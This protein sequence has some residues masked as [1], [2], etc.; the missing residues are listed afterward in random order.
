MLRLEPAAPGGRFWQVSIDAG[1]DALF[2]SQFR[3]DAIGWDG[4][5]GLTVTTATSTSPVAF[6]VA[7]LHLSAH[8]GDEY[9]DRT[10]TQRIDYT[11]EEVAFGASWKFHPRWRTYGELAR[12]Y[13]M[14]SE[15][16]EPWRWQAGVEFE[17]RPTVFGGRMAWYGAADFSA[18]QERD[19]RL[20]T[21][22]QGG[23]VTRSGGRT[24]R[25]FVQW[26][27]GRVPLGQFSRHSEAS[28]SVGLKIDL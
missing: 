25:I 23:L 5:Y 3:N 15:D 19:W 2:D 17:A 16:Q 20:D 7:L 18:L 13:I 11:R 12:A 4:N 27:D 9:E 1:L 26:Y 22:L 24:C 14:R 28:V 10:E 6:K 8:L 21:A